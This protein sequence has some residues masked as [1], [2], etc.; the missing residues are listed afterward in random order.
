MDNCWL[1]LADLSAISDPLCLSSLLFFFSPVVKAEALSWAAE[2]IKMFGFGG[3]QPRPALECI[4]KG[5]ADTNPAVRT[6]A[7][8]LLG[9]RWTSTKTWF[10]VAIM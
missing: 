9:E 8:G 4:K 5:L 10:T 1:R 3:L 7:V 2:G 6:A